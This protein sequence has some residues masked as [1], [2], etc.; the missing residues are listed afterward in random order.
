VATL[1]RMAE[2]DERLGLFPAAVK[3]LDRLARLYSQPPKRAQALFRQGEILLERMNEPDRAFEA[4]L[5]ASDLD[6]RSPPIALRL[7]EGYWRAGNFREAADVGDELCRSGP[8]PDLSPLLRLR[9]T[10]AVALA[11]KD[12]AGAMAA[13]G[14]TELPFHAEVAAAG[15]AEATALLAGRPPDELGPAT[16]V[17]NA[18]SSR[19]PSG[20]AST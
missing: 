10:L 5:K 13:T 3:V 6:P 4:H 19:D 15:L 2:I 12:P 9:W 8:L 20:D 11:G 17:I 1:E 7:I 14:L 16:A 18:W